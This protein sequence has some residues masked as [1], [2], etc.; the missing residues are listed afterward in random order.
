MNIPWLDTSDL[1]FKFWA[2]FLDKGIERICTSDEISTRT[3]T[4]LQ[5]TTVFKVLGIG[6][7]WLVENP[8]LLDILIGKLEDGKEAKILIP[9]PL[10]EEI[11]ER[12]NNDEPNTFEKGLPGLARLAISWYMMMQQYK[13]LQVRLYDGYPVVNMS[14]Y[15]NYIFVSPVLYKRRGK[16]CLTA[17]FRRPSSGSSIYE[18]HFDDL[19]KTGSYDITSDYIDQISNKLKDG[20]SNG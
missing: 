4:I 14:I 13:N 20:W 3:P 16:D 5:S 9:D 7:S 19:F 10:S 6:N 18:G 12:Y 15:D 1:N 11:I 8:K 2:I 17:V